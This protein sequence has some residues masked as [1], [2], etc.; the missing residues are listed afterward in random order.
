MVLGTFKKVA[1]NPDGLISRAELE[2]VFKEL[3]EWSAEDLEQM[4]NYFDRDGFGL[5][6]YSEFVNWAMAADGASVVPSQ[7]PAEGDDSDEEDEDDDSCQQMA[8]C[9]PPLDPVSLDLNQCLSC[10][11]WVMLSKR[12]DDDED[13]ARSMYESLV[14]EAAE[15]GHPM[16]GGVFLG[17]LLE[18]I[19]ITPTDKESMLAVANALE[20]VK[21][22]L[23]KGESEAPS[24]NPLKALNS[25]IAKI[26]RGL[27]KVDKTPENGLQD[28]LAKNT[29]P[30]SQAEQ[31]AM[32]S[33]VGKE[34]DL[35]ARVR[36]ADVN[37]PLI[38]ATAGQ[39]SCAER[40][41]AEVKAIV[42]RCKA[43]GTK[44]TDP[45]F[46]PVA[47]FNDIMY[48]DHSG[49]GFD[50]TV[51]KPHEFKRLTEIVDGPVLFKDGIVA[52]DI[53]QGQIGTCFLLGAMGAVAA[54]NPS[55]IRKCFIRYNVEMG[56]YGVRFNLDGEW[57]YIIVDDIFPVD[58]YGRLIYAKS[59]DPQEVWCPLLEKAFCKFHTCYE[60]CDGGLA[61]E[62]IF[63][64]FGGTGGKL[65]VGKKDREDASGYFNTLTVAMD[66][67]WLLTT[68]FVKQKGQKSK[69]GGKCG[70]D[71]CPSGLVF[72]HVYSV[73]RVVE[74]GGNKLIQIRNPWGQGEW[75]G[76]WSDKNTNGEWTDEMKAA[77]GFVGDAKDGKFWMSVDDYVL[78]TNGADYARPFGPSWKKV[79]QFKAFQQGAPVAAAQ[80]AYKAASEGELAFNRGDKVEVEQMAP[81]WWYGKVV[82]GQLKGFFPGNYVKLQDRP[83]MRFDI[84][85]VPNAGPMNVVC[86][87]LQPNVKME[88]KFYKRKKDGLNY[89]D[90]K[91]P[92]MQLIIIGPDG[93]VAAKKKGARR[94]LSAEVSLPAAG[95]WKVY[96]LSLSGDASKF[97]VRLYAKGGAASLKEVPGAQLSEI[98]AAL[99]TK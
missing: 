89:K 18:E 32:S 28:L 11:E 79:T 45:Q 44:F 15:A 49:P 39:I 52:G 78:N 21:A 41:T 56:V 70:E 36:A 9:M 72:G 66:R 50:C 58:Q 38:S 59:R 13:E 55:A 31:M 73:L 88:R 82:G 94:E 42:G 80:W 98:T 3:D 10:Q 64:F 1:D 8:K 7:A 54:H 63:S 29:L 74:A 75:G 76:K 48:V 60:M 77:V 51:A 85:A 27:M 6:K 35:M 33:F 23:A 22:K 90:T 2:Q 47:N 67:G 65:T 19:K 68:T 83:V 61:T 24:S 97:S 4:L 95:Q 92:S 71:V 25:G 86:L 37:P 5:I 62:A 57:T 17:E 14:E 53:V 26:L 91:Y 84:D 20:D 16:E 81:G 96:C 87:L 43:S 93:K 40:C 34:A 12:L 46:N 99:A 30:F 69:S